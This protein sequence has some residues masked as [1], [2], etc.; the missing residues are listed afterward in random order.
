M[1][2]RIDGLVWL[3]GRLCPRLNRSAHLYV[4]GENDEEDC[5]VW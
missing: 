3:R 1:L 2:G 5:F 4:H